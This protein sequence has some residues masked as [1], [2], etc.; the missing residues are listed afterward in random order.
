MLNAVTATTTSRGVG[1]DSAGRVSLQLIAAGV[2]AGIGTFTVD[3]SNNG[4]ATWSSYQRLIS[5][6][7]GTNSQTDAYVA[8][9][10][11]NS[12]GS[13]MLFIPASDTFELIRVTCTAITDGTYS[14]ALYLN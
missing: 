11:I 4:G 6:L 14:A 5:N 8:N 2:T 9:K 3:V 12:T 7:I 13:S 1:V 10:V